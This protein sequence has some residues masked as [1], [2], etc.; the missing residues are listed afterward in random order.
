MDF[1][2]KFR[3]SKKLANYILIE[4]PIGEGT[5]GKV[6]RCYR[7]DNLSFPYAC[8]CLNLNFYNSNPIFIKKLKEELKLTKSLSHSKI[9]KLIDLKRT[10]KN[11]YMI[12]EYINGD[13]LE[14]FLQRYDAA[15]NHPPSMTLVRYLSS[16][17]TIGLYYLFKKSIIHRDV[18]LENL[19]FHFTEVRTE[20][21]F[22]QEDIQELETDI[23]LNYNELKLDKSEY[24]INVKVDR[25]SKCNSLAV[26][27]QINFYNNYGCWHNKNEV[28]LLIMSTQ[29]KIIDFGLGKD[30]TESQGLTS[31]VCGSPITMA[32][33]IWLNKLNKDS[34]ESYDYKVDIWSLGCCLFNI[35]I[36]RSP[37]AADEIDRICYKVVNS[38]IYYLPIESGNYGQ[39]TVEFID[40][41]NGML[42]FNKEDRMSWEEIIDHPFLNI[43]Y[44]KQTKIKDLFKNLKSEDPQDQTVLSKVVYKQEYQGNALLMSVKQKIDLLAISKKYAFLH[45]DS[46]EFKVKLSLIFPID[47]Y[48]YSEENISKAEDE[49]NKAFNNI[50]EIEDFQFEEIEEGFIKVDPIRKAE[51]Y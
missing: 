9:I 24:L 2:E 1:K 8:K 11:L 34:K 10:T 12:M 32:P 25:L 20:E 5:F 19:M 51:K 31:S 15:F 41:I 22:C 42:Q 43:Q 18:K 6:Y 3:K 40:F 4:P 28:E 23:E 50:E 16:E 38:G 48:Y 37:F 13:N 29:T 36:G 49:I 7:Q 47:D 30:L 21:S 44:S 46:K 35:A 17:I 45:S 26:D 27:E 33:E 14:S 39:I